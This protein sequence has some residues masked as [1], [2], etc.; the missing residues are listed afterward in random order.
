MNMPRL[1]FSV[2][3]AVAQYMS[4]KNPRGFVPKA[5]S[6]G[7]AAAITEPDGCVPLRRVQELTKGKC[8]LILDRPAGL[9]A[10]KYLIGKYAGEPGR[11]V[12]CSPCPITL[13]YEA[14]PFRDFVRGRLRVARPVRWLPPAHQHQ[15]HDHQPAPRYQR[16]RRD[17][18][19]LRVRLGRGG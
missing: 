8:G 15:Q 7:Y 2:T 6:H 17:G 16:D 4:G 11:E 9:D 14:A 1:T 19:P 3:M 12:W 18:H 13:V 5:L 10:K